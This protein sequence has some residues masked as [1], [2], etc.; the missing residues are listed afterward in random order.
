MRKKALVR[1][2]RTCYHGIFG[3]RQAP[4]PYG[5]NTIR[6]LMNVKNN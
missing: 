1:S 3:N 2:Y 4:K 6:S 5:K